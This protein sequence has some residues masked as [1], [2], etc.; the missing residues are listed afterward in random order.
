MTGETGFSHARG[1]INRLPCVFARALLAHQAVCELAVTSVV[2]PGARRLDC[3]QP[4][5]RAVCLQMLALLREKSNFALGIGA[6]QRV[7]PPRLATQLQCGGLE[8]LR[9]ALDAGAPAPDVRRLLRQARERYGEL[10]QLPFAEVVK[11][12]AAWPSGRRPG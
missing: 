8:G 10:D 3:A 1:E 4:V 6:K 2:R 7:L 12:V 5:A 9:A 11:G